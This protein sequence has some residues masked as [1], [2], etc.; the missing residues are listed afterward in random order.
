MD[1]SVC[2]C[3]EMVG[4]EWKVIKRLNSKI[5]TL[6]DLKGVFFLLSTISFKYINQL[7]KTKEL[8]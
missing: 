6:S 8:I 2:E 5:E 1:G 3:E 4:G 7:C